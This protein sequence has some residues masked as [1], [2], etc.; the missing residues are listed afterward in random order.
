[1]QPKYLCCHSSRAISC[2]CPE[3]LYG[4]VE[5][6]GYPGKFTL[7]ADEQETRGYS[8]PGEYECDFAILVM[9]EHT[10]FSVGFV[11]ATAATPEGR[12]CAV[13]GILKGSITPDLVKVINMAAKF[14][15][16]LNDKRIGST[17]IQSTVYD[18]LEAI[19]QHDVLEHAAVAVKE[20]PA[21]VV[22]TGPRHQSGSTFMVEGPDTK[23]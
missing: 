5:R 9:K 2:A 3:A 11:A 13:G 17:E 14:F 20:T 18:R 22:D 6:I 21:T 1:M 10:E 16:E 4:H 8:G 15:L 23:Q 12:V 7:Y 19:W